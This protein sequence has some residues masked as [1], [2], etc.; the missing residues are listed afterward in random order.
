MEHS[1]FLDR[2]SEDIGIFAVSYDDFER[3]I[4][5]AFVSSV[6]NK[7]AFSK[8]FSVVYTEIRSIFEHGFIAKEAIVPMTVQGMDKYLR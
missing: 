5:P 4:R 6:L 2:V 8:L 7:E 1:E 3:H